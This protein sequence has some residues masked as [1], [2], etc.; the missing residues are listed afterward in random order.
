M[1]DIKTPTPKDL[2]GEIAPATA[3]RS[4]WGYESVAAGL[5][6]SR[7]ASIIR[8]ANDGDLNAYLTLAEEME[9]RDPHYSSVIRTRKLAVAGLD[10]EVTPTSDSETDVKISNEIKQI[11]KTAH[12]DNLIN[13]LLDAIGKGYSVAEIMWERGTQWK[14]GDFIWRDPRFFMPHPKRPNELRIIDESDYLNGKEIPPYKFIVHKPHMKSG[15]AIRGGLARLVALSYVCKMYSLKD[16]LAFVEVYGKPIR[17]GRYGQNATAKDK[18]VLKSALST[19]GSDAAAI[20]PE[21]MSVEIVEAVKGVSGGNV[22]FEKLANW[23]DRQVSKAVLGQT[24]TT[25]DGSSMAQALVHN[26]VRSDLIEADAK[27]LAATLNRDFI[28]TYIDLNYGPQENYPTI[29]ILLPD[30][31]DLDAEAGRF[32]TLVNLGLPASKKQAYARFGISP[33]EDEDD[34]LQRSA[35]N[36]FEQ[37]RAE[38]RAQPSGCPGCGKALNAEGSDDADDIDEAVADMMQDWQQVMSPALEA[39][40]KAVNSATSLEDLRATLGTISSEIDTSEVVAV[41]ASAT[42]KQH[43]DGIEGK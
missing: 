23:L 40:K 25:D 26:D 4:A 19:I 41:L 18:Q 8:E 38:N 5:T 24:M 1:A 14:P 29:K 31:T 20:L 17:L 35:A 9:E 42:F 32:E 36:P 30:N 27:Q 12:F 43:G 3:I 37:G 7:L 21:E 33:P 10:I 2:T 11:T 15:L 22:A 28:K 13:D 39:V 16:W 34:T 6:P